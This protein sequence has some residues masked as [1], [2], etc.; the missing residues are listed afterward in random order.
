MTAPGYE[1]RLNAVRTCAADPA[2]KIAAATFVLALADARS[3]HRERRLDAVRWL[4]NGGTGAYWAELL[5]ASEV[6]ADTL[7]E[8]E[9]R[10][11]FW[12]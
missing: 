1:Q 11:S 3:G 5:G 12:R 4:G 9:E 2:A 8:R 10:E 7:A 6:L